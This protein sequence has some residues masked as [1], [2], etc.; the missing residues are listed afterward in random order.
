MTPARPATRTRQPIPAPVTPA[1]SWRVEVPG[2]VPISLNRI[3]G[4]W[5]KAGRLKA[6]EARTIATACAL[7]KVPPVG[8]TKA[9]RKGRRQLGITGRLDGDPVPTKRHV[10]LEIRLGKGE[11]SP[12]EDNLFKALMDGLKSAGMLFEDT[13][14]W[15]SHDAS[16]TWHRGAT[17]DDRMTVIHLTEA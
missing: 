15:C 4:H 9:E 13:R 8:L 12:D 11:R 5:A 10:R 1:R 3:V 14:R 7:A 6:A 2:W 16:I 17:K